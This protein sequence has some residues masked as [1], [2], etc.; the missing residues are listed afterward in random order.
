MITMPYKLQVKIDSDMKAMLKLL[1]TKYSVKITA[2]TR[3][4]IRE[5]IKRDFKTIKTI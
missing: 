2:F 1:E 4:A 5:K 3:A